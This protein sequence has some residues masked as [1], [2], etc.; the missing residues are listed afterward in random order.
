MAT[1][2]VFFQIVGANFSL[3]KQSAT[4]DDFMPEADEPVWLVCEI[5]VRIK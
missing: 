1:V 3:A 5:F 4:A 2:T